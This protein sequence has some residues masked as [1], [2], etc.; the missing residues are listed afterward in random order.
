[1][2]KKPKYYVVWR[3][4]DTGIFTTWEQCSQQVEGFADAEYKAF[5]NR[6]AAER[7]FQGGYHDYRG[8]PAPTLSAEEI[9]LI[10][11]PE[12]E[13]YSVDASCLGYPGPVEY[14]CVHTRTKEVVFRR[15]PFAGGGSNLGEFL[16]LVHALALFKNKGISLPIYSDSRT[17]ISWVRRKKCKSRVERQDDNRVLFELVDRAVRWLEANDYANAILTWETAAWGDIPAD[18]GRK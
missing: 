11:E 6:D 7:A 3:G 16:A 15:G 4:R 10:G 14:R 13:S 1:M 5:S 17:A 2:A 8:K 12:L 18:F 9:A